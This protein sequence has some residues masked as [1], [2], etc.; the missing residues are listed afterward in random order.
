[1][2]SYCFFFFFFFFFAF[3]F[4]LS[5]LDFRT[6]HGL[7][8]CL[9]N[10]S[11]VSVVSNV[12]LQVQKSSICWFL[13]KDLSFPPRFGPTSGF[14]LRNE[15]KRPTWSFM[16]SSSGSECFPCQVTAVHII[17]TVVHSW[18]FILALMNI[19]LYMLFS[20]L[21]YDRKIRHITKRITTQT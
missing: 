12:M 1:M 19:F 13:F 21:H 5:F 14:L 10:T 20:G 11:G 8:F 7:K 6:E 4:F 18:T 9:I 2:S 15:N 3:C 16:F 17:V